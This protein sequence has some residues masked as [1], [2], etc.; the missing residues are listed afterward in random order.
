MRIRLLSVLLLVLSLLLGAIAS[1]AMADER[2]GPRE[3][4]AQRLEEAERHAGEPVEDFHYWSIHGWEALG[5]QQV[6]VWTRLDEAWLLDLKNPCSG[7]EF[8]KS[9]ALSSTGNR[10]YRRFD[11]VLFE[12]QRCS[13]D[14]IRPVDGKAL[15]AERRQTRARHDD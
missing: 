8:A 12:H 15:K 14:R 9:I 7:L 11:A 2:P 10:V 6:L 1:P 3:R 5:P 13:I 4:A